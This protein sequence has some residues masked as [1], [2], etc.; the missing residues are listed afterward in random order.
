[1]AERGSA[2]LGHGGVA[3]FPD[4]PYLHW[5]VDIDENR[6]GNGKHADRDN[7]VDYLEACEKMHG[8]FVDFAQRYFAS[9]A[10]KEFSAISNRIETIIRFEGVKENRCA[11]WVEA[12]GDKSIYPA[13][14][15]E[16]NIQFDSTI[17]EDEKVK[18]GSSAASEISI[19]SHA[20]K[21]HQ[22]AALHRQY[23]LKELLPAHGIAVY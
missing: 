10:P 13:G 11:Q 12:I 4:R 18:F 5:K 15:D 3:T 19:D 6:P 16:V 9:S 7:P 8:Y 22:A 2:S 17:W 23:V 1:M 21:F 20:Y 14:A